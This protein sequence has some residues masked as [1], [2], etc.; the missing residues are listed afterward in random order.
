MTRLR[1]LWISTYN[2]FGIV[3]EY[4]T[5]KMMSLDPLN[6]AFLERLQRM[7]E[8]SFMH[9]TCTNYLQQHKQSSFQWDARLSGVA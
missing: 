7:M 3:A 9:S 1:P 4:A 2:C 8:L 5:L 6:D